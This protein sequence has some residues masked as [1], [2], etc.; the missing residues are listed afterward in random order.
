[1]YICSPNKQ[2]NHR[3][4]PTNPR[5]Y[6]YTHLPAYAA[7]ALVAVRFL[8]SA[9]RTSVVFLRFLGSCQWMA[10]C[11]PEKPQLSLPGGDWFEMWMGWVEER[12]RVCINAVRNQ[13]INR[14]T[15]VHA[16]TIS[17]EINHAI[18]QTHTHQRPHART[19]LHAGGAVEVDDCLEPQLLAPA[20]RPDMDRGLMDGCGYV[21]V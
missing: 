16:K 12:V 18:K 7:V 10:S 3:T 9:T 1:M 6:P 11:P 20:Q 19:I 5:T 21:Y 13:L 14:P 4:H 2:A 17:A 8:A 15:N